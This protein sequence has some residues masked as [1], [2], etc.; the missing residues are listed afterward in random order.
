MNPGATPWYISSLYY[1]WLRKWWIWC[2]G[3]PSTPS[4]VPLGPSWSKDH[5]QM[6]RP[7]QNWFGNWKPVSPLKNYFEGQIRIKSRLHLQNEVPHDRNRVPVPEPV[8]EPGMWQLFLHVQTPLY[9]NLTFENMFDESINDVTF[10][11]ALHAVS[12]LHL[13]KAGVILGRHLP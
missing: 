12:I 13:T 3:A 10:G 6:G 9:P 5:T 8:P 11:G 1:I 7:R 2:A 4:E